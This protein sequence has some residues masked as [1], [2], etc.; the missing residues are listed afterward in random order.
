MDLDKYKELAEKLAASREQDF[1]HFDFFAMARA[2]DIV[3]AT[4]L[5]LRYF[6]YM[7]ATYERTKGFCRGKVG[8]VFSVDELMSWKND[9][10]RPTIENYD[11]V[12]HLGGENCFEG[13]GHCNHGLRFISNSAAVRMRPE[14]GS[15]NPRRI[16]SWTDLCRGLSEREASLVKEF[17]VQVNMGRDGIEARAFD[18]AARKA[19]E[20]VISHEGLHD[21]GQRVTLAKAI[22]QLLGVFGVQG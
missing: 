16:P 15:G 20:R 19:I 6:V 10:D 11:P 9:P 12:L 14:L 22:P 3:Q 13:E 8:K 1:S 4:T 21:G 18:M 17:A 7:G 5:G 2:Q